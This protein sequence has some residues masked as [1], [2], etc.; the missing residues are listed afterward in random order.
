MMSGHRS[1]TLLLLFIFALCVILSLSAFS[2]STTTTSTTTTKN[3]VAIRQRDDP[4]TTGHP[5]VIIQPQLIPPPPTESINKEVPSET[6]PHTTPADT[7]DMCSHIV[8]KNKRLFAYGDSLTAG[9]YWNIPKRKLRYHPYKTHLERLLRSHFRDPQI[10]VTHKGYPGWPSGAL[11]G[12]FET[13]FVKQHTATPFDACILLGGTN[14][15]LQSRSVSKAVE[16]IVKMHRLC[17]AHNVP[18][19][20]LL[21]PP[22]DFSFGPFVKGLTDFC[23]PPQPNVVQMNRKKLN[24]GIVSGL[25]L[26]SSSSSSSSC[27]I[28]D[29]QSRLKH[30][31]GHRALWHDC[32]H[33]TSDG[34]EIVAQLIFEHLKKR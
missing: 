13:E 14:D 1:S 4:T 7:I 26:L 31:A 2:S 29:P 11:Q 3:G 23:S 10:N 20:A 32:V 17:H 34:Y 16:N 30:D 5:L 9:A 24:E 25:A 18:S 21:L 15:V 22:I 27:G 6:K 19:V 33:P 8:L 12:V 28:I